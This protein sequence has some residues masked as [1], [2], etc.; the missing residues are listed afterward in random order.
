MYTGTDP[1]PR[2]VRSRRCA[3]EYPIV[4]VHG[5]GFQAKIMRLVDYWG[6]IP[7]LLAEH[8]ADVHVS[9]VNA[10]DSH[11]RK[12]AAWREEVLGVLEKTG[13]RRV[14]V[15]GHSDGCLYTRYAITHLGMESLVASHTSLAGPH[16]GS[17]VADIF[18]GLIP[19]THR[20]L[21]GGHLDWAATFVMG[22]VDPDFM[23][24]GHEMTRAYMNR[25]FN[26]ATPDMPGIHYRSYAFRVTNGAGAGLLCPTWGALL[27]EEGENDGLVSVASARW[28]D[29][30]GTLDGGVWSFMGGINHFAV[31]GLL[32]AATPGYDPGA[33]FMTL[34]AELKNMGF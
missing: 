2:T 31:V 27:C 16:R 25:E 13:K 33:C 19:D 34:A 7:G 18:M 12:G 32:P 20:A 28:G 29:F 21:V 11:A 4:L 6:T 15:I 10:V 23:A 3:T 30:K 24:N 22:D 26:P 9:R 1:G 5:M 14:N 17:A 8:G